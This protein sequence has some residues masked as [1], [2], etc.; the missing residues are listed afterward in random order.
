MIKRMLVPTFSLFMF[1]SGFGQQV[2]GK[3]KFEQGQTFEITL[4]IKTTIAQEAGG[5]AIDFNVDA[6]GT[7]SYKVTN[8]TPDNTTLHHQVNV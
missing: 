2:A 5:Q 4:Q 6:S 7:H 3:L 1:Y 8:V